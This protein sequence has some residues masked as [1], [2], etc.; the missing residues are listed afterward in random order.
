MNTYH[1]HYCGEDFTFT[2]ESEQAAWDSQSD[3]YRA[4]HKNTV[5]YP[6]TRVA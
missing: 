5:H 3:H 1:C 4:E 2:A 6:P